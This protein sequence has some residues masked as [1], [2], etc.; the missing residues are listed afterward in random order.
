MSSAIKDSMQKLRTFPAA[1]P[2]LTTLSPRNLETWT[3]TTP[4]RW[5]DPSS[6][7]RNEQGQV[8]IGGEKVMFWRYFVAVWARWIEPSRSDASF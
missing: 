7:P 1:F 3:L 4:E 8:R 2:D 6:L 5:V